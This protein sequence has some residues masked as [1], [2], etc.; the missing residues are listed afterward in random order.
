VKNGHKPSPIILGAGLAGLSCAYRL[1]AKGTKVMVLEKEPVLGG[2]A[3]SREAHG[4]YYDYGPHRFHSQKTHIIDF[5]KEL[6]GDNLII[7]KRKSE[8]FMNSNFFV[9]PLSTSN[10][11]EN[12]PKH[13]LL[14]C[15]YDYILAR[16]K[17]FFSSSA[18]DSFESWVI[19]RF[20]KTLYQIFFGTYTQKVLGLPPSKISKDWAQQRIHL[21]S[22]WSVVENAIFKS[23][24]PPRAH[25]NNF[26]YPREG[27]IGQIAEA[28]AKK[29]LENGSQILLAAKIINIKCTQS[30]IG[31]STIQ[32]VVFE[33]NGKRYE[34]KVS[35]LMSTI[36][37]TSLPAL[38]DSP[39]LLEKKSVFEKVKFR[40]LIFA[41]LVLDVGLFSDSQWIYLPEE[42]FFCN[43]LSEPKNFSKYNLPD[44]KTIICAEI[45]CDYQDEKWNMDPEEVKKNVLRDIEQLGSKK[46]GKENI[47]GYFCHKIHHS[48]PVYT[49]NYK[50]DID[51]A[52][53]LLSSFEN[54]DCFGRNAL[55][56]YG[57]MD[58]VIEMGFKTADKFILKTQEM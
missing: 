21:L 10:I 3:A 13:V 7:Q 57:N 24:N 53:Q 14:K 32:S 46:I 20:G 1:A 5:L 44:N 41:Y 26:Y 18:D 4:L 25:T 30:G 31:K 47:S 22:L 42:R 29:I 19:K 55:F 56:K 36:P 52:N 34:E 16:I 11:L 12:M 35:Q 33:H 48:Y 40:S 2:L 37:I 58:H 9:Y 39:F 15:F 8:I 38:L 45:S 28:L 6:M 17:S 51:A 23:K 27:G 49:M 54:L 43:R 50:N